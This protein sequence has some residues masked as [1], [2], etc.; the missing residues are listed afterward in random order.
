MKLV[1]S[2]SYRGSFIYKDAEGNHR[3]KVRDGKMDVGPFKDKE[4]LYEH[5]DLWQKL[6]KL[7]PKIEEEST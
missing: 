4:S 7:E 1:T 3:A 5:L 6:Y 2:L